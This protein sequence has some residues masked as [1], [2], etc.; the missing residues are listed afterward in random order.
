MSLLTYTDL[1]HLVANGVIEHS[2]PECVNGA[3]IDIRLGRYLHFESRPTMQQLSDPQ[4]CIPLTEGEKLPLTT[5]AWDLV[6][7]GDF[8]LQ[9]GYCTLAQS[10]E[11]FHLPSNIAAEYKLKSSMARV[12]LEHL[13]AGWCDPGW[14]GSVL[15]LELRNLSTFHP[16]RLRY[17]DRIGQVVFFRGKKVPYEASY[18][19]LGRY[20]GNKKVTGA[21]NIQGEQK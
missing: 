2:V 9:P 15:T 16:I 12:F 11:I 6:E 20:N 5:T 1:V 10:L 8:I 14:N 17:M 18:A 21:K 7:Q 13:N 4:F 3:S 19:S